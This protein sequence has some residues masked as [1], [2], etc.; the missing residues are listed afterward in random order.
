[1][2][3]VVFNFSRPSKTA[4]WE[5]RSLKVVVPNPRA[6][7]DRSLVPPAPDV[8]VDDPPQMREMSP[9]PASKPAPVRGRGSAASGSA[10]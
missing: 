6:D 8:R 3:V 10:G 9:P 7:E 4:R 5:L 1:M 2:R